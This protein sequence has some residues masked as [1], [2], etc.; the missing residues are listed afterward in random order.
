[1]LEF[2]L[3]IL[4]GAVVVGIALLVKYGNSQKKTVRTFYSFE[5]IVAYRWHSKDGLVHIINPEEVEVI[6]RG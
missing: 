1:M 5:Q 4:T 3:G 2:L 6:R